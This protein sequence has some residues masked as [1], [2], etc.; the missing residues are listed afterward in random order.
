[1]DMASLPKKTDALALKKCYS[2]R[3]G[4]DFRQGCMLSG[5]PSSVKDDFVITASLSMLF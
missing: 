1:M 2:D 5:K 4:A 3:K